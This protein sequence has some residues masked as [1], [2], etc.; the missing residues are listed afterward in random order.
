M[1][2]YAKDFQNIKKIKKAYKTQ[3][4][5][6]IAYIDT[7][8]KGEPNTGYK[9]FAK[10]M[11]EKNILAAMK[12]A[13]QCIKTQHENIYLIDIYAKTGWTYVSTRFS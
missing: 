1:L 11:E 8:T 13:E 4:Y 3:Y 10:V 12:R 9:T 7:T 5:E 6:F 2:N